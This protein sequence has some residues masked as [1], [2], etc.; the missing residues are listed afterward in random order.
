MCPQACCRLWN[1]IDE[2]LPQSTRILRSP[3][4][5]LDLAIFTLMKESA[6]MPVRCLYTW[7]SQLCCAD[8]TFLLGTINPNILFRAAFCSI[9]RG[10][11]FFNVVLLQ[12]KI[13]Y[14]RW[15]LINL[16]NS[17]SMLDIQQFR[18]SVEY[19]IRWFF[20]CK[21]TGYIYLM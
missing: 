7:C 15:L 13:R 21:D 10:C 20:F 9:F 19:N 1:Y 11:K 16:L 2:Y 18:D 6:C 4:V 5:V 14:V 17:F 3:A 12:I 8:T